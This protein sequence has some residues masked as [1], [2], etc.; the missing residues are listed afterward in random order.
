[1]SAILELE[2][3]TKRFGAV[4]AAENLSIG[5][6]TGEA[7]GVI[8]PNGSGKT[9]MLNIITGMIRADSGRV[10]FDGIEIGQMPAF[11]R[12]RRGIARSFQIPL[13]FVGMTVFENLLVGATFGDGKPERAAYDHC[14]EIL[15]ETGLKAKS[16]LRA[17]SLPLLDRKR[18][19]LARALA[20]NPKVLLLDEIAGGLTEP[21]C[22]LL[23]QEVRRIRDRG[24]SIIWIEHVVHALLAVVDRLLVI[25]FGR[26][27]DDGEPGNVMASRAV[28]EIYMGQADDAI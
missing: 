15:E 13:P 1:M 6:N 23:V 17:G 14:A 22:R 27:I 18:L 2:N 24:V 4:L 9:T 21:E 5:L 19:E 11:E 28:K 25:N 20:T 16:N 8:G 3:I 10:V 12:C 26:K 7:L